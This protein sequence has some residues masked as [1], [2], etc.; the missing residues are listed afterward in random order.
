MLPSC[1]WKKLQ[2]FLGLGIRGKN[3]GFVS[4]WRWTSSSPTVS[5]E[6]YNISCCFFSFFLFKLV[7]KRSPQRL[8]RSWNFLEQRKWPTCVVSIK[9]SQTVTSSSPTDWIPQSEASASSSQRTR[10]PWRAPKLFTQASEN[11]ESFLPDPGLLQSTKSMFI[12]QIA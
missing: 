11:T 5:N 8:M 6:G 10:Q 4:S 7:L 3:C 1:P 12:E 9:W 2:C